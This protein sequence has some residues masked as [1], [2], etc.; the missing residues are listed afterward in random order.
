MAVATTIA[1]LLRTRRPLTVRFAAMAASVAAYYTGVLG[2]AIAGDRLALLSAR[3]IAGGFIVVTASIFFD[4]ILGEIS[5]VA[6]RRRRVPF[7]IAALVVVT[8]MTPWVREPWVSGPLVALVVLTLALR[9]RAVLARAARVD[10]QAERTR[11]RYLG[12]GGLVALL[13]SQLDVLA[14]VG[15]GAPAIGGIVVAVYL[16]FISQALLKSRLLDLHELLG[17]ALVFG[18]LALLLALVYGALNIAIGDR[19]GLFLSTTMVASSLI[20]ILFEPAK[21]ALEEA[22]AR[23]F[24]REQLTFARGLRRLV[25][26]L[27]TVIELPSALNTVLDEI[28]DSKRATHAGVWLLER[29]GMSFVLQ[30]HRGPPPAKLLDAKTHPALF[31]HLLKSQTP[32][33]REAIARRLVEPEKSKEALTGDQPRP[34][35]TTQD[36]ALVRGLD[37]LNA[38]LV[39]PLRAQGGVAGLLCLRDERLAD[40]FASDEIAAL[41]EVA[42]QLAITIENSRLFGVLR[43]RDRLA[44]LGE[45]SAGL[46]HEIRNPL[47]AIKGA[48]QELDPKRIGGDDGELMQII[49]DEV[50][51]LNVVV[52]EF[53]DYARPFRGTFVPM[54]LNDAVRRTTQLMQHDLADVEMVV[55]LQSDLPDVSGDA[56]RLQQVMIN[57]IL[58]AADAM[59]RKGRLTITTKTSADLSDLALWSLKGPRMFVEVRIKDEGPGIPT[60]LLE[61]IFIPFFTTKARGTGLGLALCQRIIQH[62][63]GAIEVRSI[64]GHGATFVVRLPALP[65]KKRDAAG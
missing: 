45:M 64:E 25:R 42:D 34:A 59:G 44:A 10:S 55:E 46:A 1:L 50:N 19:R 58:N 39:V 57:L 27:Q 61:Q 32:V 12:I 31:A 29:D 4:T 7:A 5:G 26:D 60:R 43:E 2:S 18:T 62:H 30:G 63:G 65:Q 38:D 11:L 35:P 15:V 28:Y 51:R 9:V 52:T 16:Y 6:R 37:A 8:G 17:K 48:A 21:A 24:F 13:A 56:E 20:L 40:A 23:I 33:L 49:I 36:E 3:V 47:A 53:L 41:I 54:S 14:A 22:A